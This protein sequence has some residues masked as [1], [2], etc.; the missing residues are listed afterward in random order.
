MKSLTPQRIAAVDVFRALTMFLMLFVNDIPGLKNV[1]H[2]LMHARM[3]ED[4]MGFSDTIFPAFLFCMGMSVSF[5]IQNR[6]KKG[7]NTL[8]VV[9]HIFWRTVALI[10]MGLFSLNSGGIEGGLSH[11]WFSILM[12]IGFFLTWGVYPKAVGTKKV[13]FTAMKTAGVLLLAFLV[14]YK[15]MN[16]K[17]FQI[18]WW[19]ILGLIG[20]TYAVCAG[21]YLFTRE[22]LRKNAIAWF[23][24][25]LLAVVSHSDLIP[26]EYGSRIVLLPFIP[27]DWTLHALGMSGVLTSLL[28]VADHYFGSFMPNIEGAYYVQKLC[29]GSWVLELLEGMDREVLA[30]DFLARYSFPLFFLHA[31]FQ[32]IFQAP[33][34]QVLGAALPGQVFTIAN[35]TVTVEIAL[36]ILCILGIKKVMGKRSRYLIGG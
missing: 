28:I 24:V 7:D 18:S 15:D 19:G 25:V 2:W 35:L 3:D 12:V 4:M 17:P 10:A 21:I 20:W 1:P 32:G 30:L 14:I 34:F 31:I 13:L 27:S 22:N 9:A 33:L 26:G 16:G 29:I 6:Y 11:P 36:C 5:A 23:V 8:Q